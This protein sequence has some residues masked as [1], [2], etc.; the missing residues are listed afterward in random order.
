M[1]QTHSLTTF[2]LL[3]NLNIQSLQSKHFEH[4]QFIEELNYKDI[5][6]DVFCLQEIWQIQD[7]NTVSLSNYNFVY[8]K[9]SKFRGGGVAAVL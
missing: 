3:F 6:P 8:K 1:I 2:T 4:K 9:G 5:S 7:V